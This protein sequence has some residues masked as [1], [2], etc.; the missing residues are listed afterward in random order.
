MFDCAGRRQ[1]DSGPA[2]SASGGRARLTAG[3]VGQSFGPRFLTTANTGTCYCRRMDLGRYVAHQRRLAHAA[4][5]ERRAT[6]SSVRGRLPDLV[7]C[8]RGFGATQIILFGSLV[9]D[10]LTDTSDVDI[11][12]S[13]LDPVQHFE[14]MAAAAAVMERDVDLL[15]LEDVPPTLRARIE[16][17]GERLD[18]DT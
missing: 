3:L 10:A 17:D 7:E 15:R 9:R 8:L 18:D 11:A 12:V 4:A 13:G 1:Q 16:A 5:A 14:A 2:A 6:S